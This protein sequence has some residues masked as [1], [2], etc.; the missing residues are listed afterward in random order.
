M[1]YFCY[2]RTEI[3]TFINKFNILAEH[4]VGCQS[5][6]VQEFTDEDTCLQRLSLAY[7]GLNSLPH[8]VLA[9]I[10]PN[11]KILDISHNNFE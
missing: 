2:S 9:E 11:V 4:A 10:A 6:D 5:K 1:P 7:E 8:I 3:K